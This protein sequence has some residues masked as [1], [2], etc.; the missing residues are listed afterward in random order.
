[1]QQQHVFDIDVDVIRIV[2]FLFPDLRL[3]FP[4]FDFLLSTLPFWRQTSAC[5]MAPCVRGA[6]WNVGI[7]TIP[8]FTPFQSPTC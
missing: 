4:L 1:M 7:P 8:T 2:V 5:T 3:V 6:P